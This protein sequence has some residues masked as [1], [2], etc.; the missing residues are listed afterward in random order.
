M[1]LCCQ[2]LSHDF[3]VG[4]DISGKRTDFAVLLV[5]PIRVPDCQ[6]TPVL[7]WVFGF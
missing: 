7:C 2:I 1:W 3:V 6:M 4:S 5:L